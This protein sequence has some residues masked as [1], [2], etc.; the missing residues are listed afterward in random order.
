MNGFSFDPRNVKPDEGFKVIP[1]GQYKMVIYK[2]D[3]KPTKDDNSKWYLSV[4]LKVAEGAEKEH[5]F[6]D[7]L[8]LVN[9]PQT[10][11]IAMARLSAY[12]YA[13]GHLQPVNLAADVPDGM[14]APFLHNIPFLAEVGVQGEY[15]RIKK[16]MPLSGPQMTAAP[17][18]QFAPAA[19]PQPG[20]N[21][22]GAPPSAA[23]IAAPIAPQPVPPIP[24]AA[25]AAL[26]SN[27]RGWLAHIIAQNDAGV[28]PAIPAAVVATLPG[29]VQTNPQPDAAGNFAAAVT[30]AGRAAMG[31]PAPVPVASPV[32][33]TA[34]QPVP[35]MGFPQV[36]PVAPAATA[37]APVAPVQQAPQVPAPGPTGGW[38]PTQAA[39]T[40]PPSAAPWA[41]Q[42]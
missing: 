13:V 8:N 32:A 21:A 16:V 38:S 40:V 28:Y 5:S 6:A 35:G 10:V 1:A 39:P 18:Q 34:P 33:P 36:A 37:F 11:E 4:A 2:T 25:A 19:Q 26:D 42:G 17:T 23:P 14:A 12:C 27:S 29:L 22:W 15:N 9:S 7:N 20:S 41:P 3:W 31:T 30:P 24:V